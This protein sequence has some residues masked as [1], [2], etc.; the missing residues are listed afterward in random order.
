MGVGIVMR[1]A[2]LISLWMMTGVAWAEMPAE[3][4][5]WSLTCQPDDVNTT[6]GRSVVLKVTAGST[7]TGAIVHWKAPSAG[8]STLTLRPVSENTWASR[9]QIGNEDATHQLQCMIL[10]GST[11]D[12]DTH[13][14][15]RAYQLEPS[16][17]KLAESGEPEVWSQGRPSNIVLNTPP[18]LS[19]INITR[20]AP[21]TKTQAGY[22]PILTAI[23]V[24][25]INLMFAFAI[26]L[27]L[28]YHRRRK[29]HR[30]TPL[31][32]DMHAQ[33]AE[34][35]MIEPETGAPK[36][37]EP[38][39]EP[40]PPKQDMTEHL[41]VETVVESL[42]QAVDEAAEP[43]AQKVPDEGVDI[44]TSPEDEPETKLDLNNLSF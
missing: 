41:A 23:L 11:G 13:I 40:E 6:S 8:W 3:P 37:H 9:V 7:A 22:S 15:A 10:G 25:F 20:P 38:E 5:S 19:A 2:L 27:A 29:A 44:R 39:P 16:S 36:A 18:V 43:S 26:G 12:G 34:A 1:F 4:T 14:L 35:G 31:M 28:V 17:M 24:F 21:E 42:D 32:H 33:F 30:E